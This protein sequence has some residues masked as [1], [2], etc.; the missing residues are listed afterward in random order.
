MSLTLG[1]DL[2]AFPP[3]ERRQREILIGEFAALIAR[4]PL[5]EL[6]RLR[7]ELAQLPSVDPDDET[8]AGDDRARLAL[9]EARARNLVRMLEDR[10]RLAAECLPAATVRAG[11]GV[12]RQRLHQLV[13][14]GRLVAV[15]GGE[16]RA[17]RYPAWQFGGDGRP[18]PELERMIAAARV[19]ELDPAT[20][21][22]LMTEP[23]DR[24]GGRTPADWLAGGAVEAV[25]G[26][27]ES[28]GLGPF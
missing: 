18:L 22:L 16:R 3:S 15:P 1:T 26:V 20:L 7:D 28:A 2:L 19:A 14:E 10:A 11:L 6:R 5:A 4:K 13:R 12:S 24:L 17:L 8:G 9:L 23:H 27:I 25:V 21:H